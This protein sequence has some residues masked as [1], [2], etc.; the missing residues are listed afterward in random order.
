ME[1][2]GS[3]KLILAHGWLTGMKKV[4]QVTPSSEE[5]KATFAAHMLEGPIRWTGRTSKGREG[6]RERENFQ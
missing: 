6:G 3:L 5:D 4:F 2:E 1:F